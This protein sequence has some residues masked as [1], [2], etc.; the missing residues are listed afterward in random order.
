M[1]IL[2]LLHVRVLVGSWAPTLDFTQRFQRE[3][4]KSGGTDLYQVIYVQI[5]LSNILIHYLNVK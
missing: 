4:C 3:P 1:F 5:Q 2:S